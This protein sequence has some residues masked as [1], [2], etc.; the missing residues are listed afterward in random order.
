[1]PARS[2]EGFESVAK[3]NVARVARILSFNT[4]SNE[5]YAIQGARAVQGPWTNLKIL[6]QESTND[7]IVFQFPETNPLTFYRLVVSP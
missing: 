1:M 3:V 4:V 7:Y 6:P 5:T 2:G